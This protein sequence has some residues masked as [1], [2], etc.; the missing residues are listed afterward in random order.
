MA[1]VGIQGLSARDAQHHSAQNQK[2][3]GGFIEDKCN[4]IVR[5]DGPQNFGMGSY[6]IHPQRS[7]HCKPNQGNRAK[8]FA[9]AARTVFLH[10]E[11][12]KQNDQR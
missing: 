1:H 10:N 5:A 4:G 6:V 2:G 8:Q 9:N 3:S 7:N 12:A 11:K